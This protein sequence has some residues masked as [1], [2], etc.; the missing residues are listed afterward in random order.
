MKHKRDNVDEGI[1]SRGW[2]KELERASSDL[3]PKFH[4]R[5]AALREVGVQTAMTPKS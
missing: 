3:K 1:G 4:S 2:K 5:K